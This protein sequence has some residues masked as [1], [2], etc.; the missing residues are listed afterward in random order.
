[1]PAD[2]KRPVEPHTCQYCGGVTR[3]PREAEARL[4][5]RCVRFEGDVHP[6]MTNARI[7][8]HNARIM[9]M[10]KKGG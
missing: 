1:M 6:A 4:C 9:G 5:M 3:S 2:T 8:V 7:A 10:V